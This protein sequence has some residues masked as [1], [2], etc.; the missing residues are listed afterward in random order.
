M[1]GWD[2]LSEGR[3][4]GAPI[5]LKLWREPAATRRSEETAAG[6]SRARAAGLL[7]GRS[8]CL[9]NGRSGRLQGPLASPPGGR[10]SRLCLAGCFLT[11]QTHGGVGRTQLFLAQTARTTPRFSGVLAPLCL[12]PLPPCH[13]SDS[14]AA[15]VP[16]VPARSLA[17]GGSPG[18]GISGPGA[19]IQ[20]GPWLEPIQ[21]VCP[22]QPAS[23]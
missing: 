15:G 23:L 22:G 6:S 7:S 14:L 3:R 10:L 17:A 1:L 13:L 8:Q 20:Q 9:P 18:P 4:V 16:E 11:A 12:V 2:S 21:D 5:L 19:F